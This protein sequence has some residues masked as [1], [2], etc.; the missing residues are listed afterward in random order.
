[1][2]LTPC[3]HVC[4]QVQGTSQCCTRTELLYKHTTC[5]H[6]AKISI[7]NPTIRHFLQRLTFQ[8]RRR[9]QH[10]AV[11]TSVFV[12]M[13]GLRNF[14]MNISQ[15]RV[16]LCEYAQ[17]AGVAQNWCVLCSCSVGGPGHCAGDPA[18]HVGSA[19]LDI[20]LSLLPPGN[21]QRSFMT[22]FVCS[23]VMQNV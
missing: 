5:I 17:C 21:L 20:S 22:L 1:M 3:V 9:L 10:M 6:N 23:I 15:L 18:A 8:L 13:V 2:T 12:L 14:S 11:E 7:L 19:H 4:A 16:S